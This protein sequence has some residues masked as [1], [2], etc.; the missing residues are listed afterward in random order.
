MLIE[1]TPTETTINANIT[2]KDGG[3]GIQIN[4]DD[5]TVTNS[6]DSFIDGE[7]STGIFINGGNADVTASG[8]ASVS[9]DGIGIRIDGNDTRIDLHDEDGNVPTLDINSGGRWVVL[10]GDS[11]TL[12]IDTINAVV[13]DE[14]SAL[15]QVTG[16]GASLSLSGD[17]LVENAAHGIDILGN[18]SSVLTNSLITVKDEGSQGI[19][20]AGMNSSFTNTGDINVSLN[21]TGVKIAGEQAK[22]FVDGNINV[23]SVK[24]SSDIL[25]G[26]TGI[27]ISS[28]NAQVKLNGSV[29]LSNQD[30]DTTTTAV[31]SRSLQGMVITGNNNDVQIT[32]AVD[33]NAAGKFKS[34]LDWQGV[35]V[36]GSDNNISITDGVNV[37]L[38]TKGVNNSPHIVGI[39]VVGANTAEISGT[40]T[41]SNQSNRSGYTELA[42]IS[43]GGRLVLTSDSLVNVNY[44]LVGAGVVP[45]AGVLQAHD[46]GTNINNQGVIDASHA[47]FAVI[48]AADNGASVINSGTVLATGLGVTGS[49]DKAATLLARGEGSSALNSGTIEV[50]SKASPST[51]GGSA[52]IYPL[53]AYYGLNYALLANDGASVTNVDGGVISMEGR[54]LFGVAAS[55]N[56]TAIN[57]GEILLDGFLPVTD[58][59]GNITSETP[60]ILDNKAAY[61]RGAGLVAGSVSAGYGDNATALNSGT[62]SINNSGFGMLAL[63][64][65]TVT[66]QGNINLTADAGVVSDSST[67]QLIGLGA[68]YGGKAINDT[69]GVIN[70]NTDIGR[71]FYVDSGQG[72]SIVNKG[73]INFMGAP[74][75]GSHTGSTPTLQSLQGYTVGTSANGSAGQFNGSNIDVSGV[76]VNTGFTTGTA[77]KTETFDNVFQG[78]NIA[79]AENI[80]SDSVVWNAQGTQD[81]TGNV[82]VT[83]TKNDYRDVAD[84]SVSSVAGALEAGYSNTA[85][86]QSLNLKSAAEVTNAMR[87]I[88]G[89][90]ATRAFND[91]RVLSHRFDMLAEKTVAGENGLGFN[92]VAK[93]D[94]RAELS[95]NARY[96]MLALSQ[97]LNLN[98]TQ[99]LNMEYG[100]ARLD[101]NG[102]VASAGDNSLT[103]GYSQFFGLKH[104]LKLDENLS[105][106]NALRYDNHQLDSSRSIRYGSVNEVA[107]ASNS[108]QY[109]EMKTA[110]T[111]GYE[112]RESLKFT[113][114]IGAKLRHTRDGSYGETGANDYNL[115]MDAAT[116][117]AVDAIAGIELTYIGKDG[118]A[119]TAKVEG[120]PNLSYSKSAR[121][122]SVQGA[123]GQ[124]FSVNDDQHGGG[125][126]SLSQL[127]VNY[128]NGNKALAVDAFNWQEDGITDLGMMMNVKVDF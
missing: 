85:L 71:A 68:M 96:D 80:Q 89:S 15:I 105:W 5:A 126:N 66:N 40:S 45:E 102:D 87:Q 27:D 63:K 32:G 57:E 31:A 119:A 115:K 30:I 52:P 116:E 62:V 3:T 59:E 20:I 103:G 78:S 91:A 11:S 33:L 100:I 88:S 19:N 29:A 10:N 46:A 97:T 60:Y 1:G 108:Q 124:Q 49:S 120:G 86:Y 42:D 23:T 90:T 123:S 50:L 121:T 21:S 69:T 112:L 7:G 113:P 17:V 55:K 24:D 125:I 75:D 106:E 110:L 70:I 38:D 37:S 53:N 118:W 99:S 61:F 36:S 44:A 51:A 41:V 127:G 13:Q 109:I 72:S 98:S 67:S 92:V 93:G 22:V 74:D 2:A 56:G 81:A 34:G 25:Q 111:K 73:T 54:A 48:M 28:N 12:S 101:G 107:N 8:D 83:M 58:S 95:G 79:G 6:G 114:S 35:L 64:G 65:G 26:A 128:R 84:D 104:S 4:G 43:A 39:N 122:G 117:T 77:A 94:Q 9:H 18:D 14:N 82:D 16:E 76:T 47:G